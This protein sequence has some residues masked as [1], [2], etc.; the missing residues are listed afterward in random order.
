MIRI[1]MLSSSLRSALRAAIRLD[2]SRWS[3]P[4][5]DL[6]RT[7]LVFRCDMLGRFLLF[8]RFERYSHFECFVVSSAFGFQF[9]MVFQGVAFYLLTLGPNA[10][11]HIICQYE[12]D[13]VQ[14]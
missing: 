3:A 10:G 13:G 5:R 11:G 6:R 14:T 8:E 1:S 7:N 9:L 4:L 2:V 12:F